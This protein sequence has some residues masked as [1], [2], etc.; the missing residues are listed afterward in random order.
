MSA[1]FS[2]MTLRSVT[3]PD[4]IAVSPVRQYSA[5]GGL[6]DERHL[7]HLGSRAVG[8]AGLVLSE[9]TA[10]SPVGWISPA[11]TGSWSEAHVGAWRRKAST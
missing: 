3:L 5:R 1:L 11:D 8:G 6:P 10:V 4:R 9:A 7:V 2:P